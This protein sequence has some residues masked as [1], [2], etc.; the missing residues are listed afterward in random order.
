MVLR[1][2]SPE[3]VQPVIVKDIVGY[4]GVV[5]SDLRTNHHHMQL[6]QP[7]AAIPEDR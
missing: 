7:H 1:V 5:V 3:K 2:I 4:F 6:L